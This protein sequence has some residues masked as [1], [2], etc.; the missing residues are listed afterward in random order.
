M[1]TARMSKTG[2]SRSDI[3]QVEQSS[4]CITNMQ[5][6]QSKTSSIAYKHD[7]RAH[8]QESIKINNFDLFGTRHAL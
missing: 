1:F 6:R 3:V 7:N 2:A 8:R 4:L 5:T